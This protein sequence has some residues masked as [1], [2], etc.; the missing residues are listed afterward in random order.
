MGAD[1]LLYEDYWNYN[2]RN[3]NS[4]N[5]ISYLYTTIQFI[6]KGIRT[7]LQYIWKGFVFVF[8]PCKERIVNCCHKRDL[9]LHPH[10]DPGYNSFQDYGPDTVIRRKNPK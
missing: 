7:L 6:L 4:K 1:S 3:Y 8:Y 5:F 9:E 10:Q 2:Y